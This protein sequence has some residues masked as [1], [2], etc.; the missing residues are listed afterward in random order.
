MILIVLAT[1]AAVIVG[2]LATALLTFYLGSSGSSSSSYNNNNNNS[3]NK[4]VVVLDLDD[5]LVHVTQ[6]KNKAPT[7]T[8]ESTILLRPGCL[9]FLRRTMA[10]YE[11]HIFTAADKAYAQPIIETLELETGTNQQFSSCHF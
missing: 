3:N 7:L 1:A 8:T 9:D 6:S 4:L 11:T 5:C 10:K 2:W